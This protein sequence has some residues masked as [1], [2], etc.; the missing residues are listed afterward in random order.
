MATQ[1]QHLAENRWAPPQTYRESV[2]VIC[3]CVCVV[4]AVTNLNVNMNALAY[5]HACVCEC[6][7]EQLA[8]MVSECISSFPTFS[9]YDRS[10]NCDKKL[11]SGSNSNMTALKFYL[12]CEFTNNQL[13][14]TFNLVKCFANNNSKRCSFEHRLHVK[15]QS[16]N[17]KPPN[18]SI[19]NVSTVHN[20]K[21]K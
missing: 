21:Y 19:L 17:C 20:I 7:K 13:A 10:S 5:E 9:T 18:F 16:H 3:S 15:T 8:F 4:A 2:R 14:T 11:L 1:T 6:C 12:P